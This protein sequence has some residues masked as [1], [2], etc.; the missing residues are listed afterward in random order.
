MRLIRLFVILLALACVPKYSHAT[1]VNLTSSTQYL[2]YQD[3]LANKSNDQGD[4]AEYVR[5]NVTKLDKDGNISIYGYGRGTQQVTNDVY[6]PGGGDAQGRLYYLYIDYRNV[7]KDHLDLRAG[8]TYVNATAVSGTLDGLYLNLKNVGGLIGATA[9]GGREVIFQNKEEIGNGNLM[10]GASIYLDTQKNTHVELSYGNK[11][12]DGRI[13][14]ETFALDFSSIPQ[15]MVKVYGTVKYDNIS[16][17]L[18]ELLFGVKLVP[19]KDLTLNVEYEQTRP[20]FD[21]NSIYRLFDVDRYQ[22][23]SAAVEYQIIKNYKI[24]LKYAKEFFGED[25]EANVYDIGLLANP[26]KDLTLN[27]SYE[28]RNGYTGQLSGFRV[29]AGYDINQ[30]TKIQAGIDYDDFT[31]DDSRAGIAKKYWGALSYQFNKMV[32][33]TGRGEY[34]RNYESG[35]SYQGFVALNVKY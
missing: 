7:V 6:A 29:N 18:N 15:E 21:N 14:R 26:I 9:F 19:I 13:A 31:R 8:R 20:T 11:F 1:E 30:A 4:V 12:R 27:L 10:N 33:V 35:D 3:F 32:G 17:E 2:W 5:L 28:I 23:I 24:K 16:D 25:T 22:E 34:D